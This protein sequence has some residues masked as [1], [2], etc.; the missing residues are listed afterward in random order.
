M[1]WFLRPLTPFLDEE[2][3]R[4]SYAGSIGCLPILRSFNLEIAMEI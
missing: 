2:V 4:G 3:G 1:G